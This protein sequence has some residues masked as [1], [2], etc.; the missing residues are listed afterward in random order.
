VRFPRCERLEEVGDGESPVVAG[1][2]DVPRGEVRHC[3]HGRGRLH[4]PM[5][6]MRRDVVLRARRRVRWMRAADASTAA[7]ARGGD[8]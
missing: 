5:V 3:R 2:Y 8:W 1:D 7:R 4:R 6:M